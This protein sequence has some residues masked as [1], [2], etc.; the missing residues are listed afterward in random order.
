VTAPAS[1]APRFAPLSTIGHAG[2]PH[3]RETI[4]LLIARF[5]ETSVFAGVLLGANRAC[6]GLEL[7][8]EVG[9]AA[10]EVASSP[11]C[12]ILKEVKN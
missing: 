9:G 5:I 4:S 1:Y 7:Y 11:T 12:G 2:L 10:N 6:G 3:T 8:L